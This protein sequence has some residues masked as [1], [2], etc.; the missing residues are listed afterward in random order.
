[1][2]VVLGVVLLGRV[3]LVHG[4]LKI[5]PSK[6]IV[7]ASS[8]FAFWLIKGLRGTLSFRIAGDP[9]L[10]K[11]T[12]L[13]SGAGCCARGAVLTEARAGRKGSQGRHSQRLLG[14]LQ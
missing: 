14:K 11:M 9:V 7:I 1:M 4:T 12:L 8:L 6:L 3:F 13:A 5:F 10:T 2:S